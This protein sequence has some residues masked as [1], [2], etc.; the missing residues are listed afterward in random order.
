MYKY[1]ATEEDV[2]MPK[3]SVYKREHRHNVKADR[4]KKI[5]SKYCN[6]AENIHLGSEGD[7][8]VQYRLDNIN[9]TFH[10][11]FCLNTIHDCVLSLDVRVT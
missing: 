6:A 7:C 3:Q 4:Y 11:C 5:S 2:S 8:F 1:I 9:L 10:R